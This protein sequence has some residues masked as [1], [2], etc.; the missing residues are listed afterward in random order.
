LSAQQAPSKIELGGQ[1][2]YFRLHAG[3]DDRFGFGV[4]FTYNFND[5]YSLDTEYDITPSNKTSIKTDFVGGRTEEFFIGPKI[6]GRKQRYGAFMKLR[7]GVIRTANVLKTANFFSINPVCS[8]TQVFTSGPRT[9]FLLDAGA[10][11]EMYPYKKWILRYDVSDKI[12]FYGDGLRTLNIPPPAAP[13]A[14]NPGA[15][16]NVFNMTVGVSYRFK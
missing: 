2:D 6:G 15:A 3:T 4:R 13:L 16:S 12:I 11:F 10:V 8:C 7:P 5:L 14:V 1:F 9:D